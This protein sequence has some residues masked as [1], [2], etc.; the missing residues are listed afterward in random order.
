[1][2][3]SCLNLGDPCR[4]NSHTSSDIPQWEISYPAHQIGRQPIR[5]SMIPVEH[6]RC[7]Y[8]ISRTHPVNDLVYT[9]SRWFSLGF[10]DSS[11]RSSIDKFL[12]APEK[13]LF[14]QINLPAQ[15]LPDRSLADSLGDKPPIARPPAG[16]K[17]HH[18]VCRQPLGRQGLPG[19]GSIT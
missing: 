3:N 19:S 5:L 7:R 14:P 17:A 18:F 4:G 15:M 1:M 16:E 2:L 8:T 6:L 11:C 12:H 13:F 9:R 10:G